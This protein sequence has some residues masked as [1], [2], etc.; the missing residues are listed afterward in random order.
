MERHEPKLAVDFYFLFLKRDY[1]SFQRGIAHAREGL[2]TIGEE[3]VNEVRAQCRAAYCH[4]L[5]T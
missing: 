3:S 4:V 5:N 1:L 2:G